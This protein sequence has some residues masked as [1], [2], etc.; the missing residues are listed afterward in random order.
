MMGC[1]FWHASWRW[2]VV[3]HVE[4]SPIIPPGYDESTSPTTG[5]FRVAMFN[6]HRGRN[7]N[8]ELDIALTAKTLEGFDLIA[9]TEVVGSTLNG[10]GDQAHLLGD[11]LNMLA[12]FFPVQL[13]YYR[14]YHGNGLLSR[15][16][17]EQ[18]QNEPLPLRARLHRHRAISTS[19]V[20]IGEIVVPVIITH[21]DNGIDRHRQLAIALNQFRQF[22]RAIL[23]G[24]FNTNVDDPQLRVALN[25]YATDTVG[26]HF[27]ESEIPG[28]ID[29]ILTRGLRPVASGMRD[30]DASD[31]ACYW[32]E[33]ELDPPALIMDS[34][35]S[36]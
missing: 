1:V 35:L 10:R 17:I 21:L 12:V 18:W 24:D 29:W 5:R 14:N 7:R 16:P 19:M 33:I 31:H 23:M 6:I 20:R 36:P 26:L 28:R 8:G 27:D 3:A 22:D 4:S 11:A 32:V 15:F 9:I 13:R 30:L 25:E 34:T 2:P